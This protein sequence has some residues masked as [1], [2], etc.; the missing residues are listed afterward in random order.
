MPRWLRI[1]L[2]V[3]AAILALAVFAGGLLWWKL[4]ARVEA[5]PDQL[6]AAPTAARIGA[7][8]V[9]G[10]NG[11]QDLAL[12]AL[13]GKTT[14]L[15]IEGRESMEAG[16]SAAL[17]S[18]LN[19]WELPDS[20]AGF[21][22]AELEGFGLLA[23]K[24]N[25]FLAF[26]ATESRFPVYADYQGTLL[27]AFELPKG[28][29]GVVVVAPD[30]D[31]AL[32]HSGPTG[33]DVLAALRA[34]LGAREPEPLAPATP[35]AVG[36]L[37]DQSCRGG[38]CAFAF[39]G[40][41]L[42][43]NQI[44]GIDGGFEGGPREAAKQFANPSIRLLATFADTALAEVA[45]RGAVLGPSDDV[46]LAKGWTRLADDPAARERFG[47]PADQAALVIVDADGQLVFRESGLVPMYKL[48][49]ARE[50]L[51]LPR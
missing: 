45:S 42:T 49:Y 33:D 34:A 47:L 2:K 17:M 8:R 7:L 31:V 39:L 23:F 28:H 35:F 10:I 11:A 48:L 46:P 25:E 22:V 26:M 21:F 44:P 3:S 1:L 13:R 24:V 50:L 38:P 15:L 4:R 43:R 32:R 51:G 12:A 27:R 37:S 18:A 20:V 19:R 29:T 14:L 5:I 16:E 41:R 36:P 9:P 30:G 40:E 6:A